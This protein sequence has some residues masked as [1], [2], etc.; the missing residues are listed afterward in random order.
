MGVANTLG[1]P[2]CR[3]APTPRQGGEEFVRPGPGEAVSVMLPADTRAPSCRP[4]RRGLRPAL[5]LFG[6]TAVAFDGMSYSGAVR[7]DEARHV[8]PAHYYLDVLPGASEDGLAA[9]RRTACCP[10][11]QVQP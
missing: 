7:T 9:R 3:G 6:Y 5:P 2:A 4:I 8:D 1:V 11:G 10:V